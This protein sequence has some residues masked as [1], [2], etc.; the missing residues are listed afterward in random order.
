MP[1]ADAVLKAIERYMET[2]D[3]LPVVPPTAAS[4]AAMVA[5]SGLGQ[6]ESLGQLPPR[7]AEV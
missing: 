6:D 5:A 3:G 4:V 7:L 1:D 2:G